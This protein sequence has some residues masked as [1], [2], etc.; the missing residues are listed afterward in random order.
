[1]DRGIRKLQ[2]NRLVRGQ[3]T[4]VVQ[5]AGLRSKREVES[6]QGDGVSNS[7]QGRKEGK[8]L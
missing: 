8:R 1:M 7:S 4:E 5:A 2:P 6:G 3:Q